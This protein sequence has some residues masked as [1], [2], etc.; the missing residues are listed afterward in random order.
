MFPQYSDIKNVINVQYPVLNMGYVQLSNMMPYPTETNYVPPELMIVNSA[1]TSF[2]GE[3]KGDVA[4]LKL[5]KYLYLHRHTT[6]FEM[7]QFYFKIH[8]P[9]VVW[10]QLVRHRTF[11]INMQSGRYTP[12]EEND[13]YMPENWRCQSETNKQGSS[14]EIISLEEQ[15]KIVS[16]FFDGYDTP[17]ENLTDLLRAYYS[18]GHKIYRA[19]LD[20]GGAKEQARL[21]L[22]AWAS[23]YTGVFSIDLHNLLRFLS[24]RNSS[25]AQYEIRQY[26]D[27][28]QNKILTPILPNLMKIISETIDN[29]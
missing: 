28:I 11:S 16:S 20:A 19:I 21:F 8:A 23:Y 14:N 17:I 22:P 9:V 5:L 7:V 10:W 13:F 12:F 15:K 29:P 4:D 27:A 2:L 26:A 25:D 1:R 18:N 6:P 3:S 24:L